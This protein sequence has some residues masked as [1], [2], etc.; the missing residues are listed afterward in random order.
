MEFKA[1]VPHTLYHYSYGC[2]HC[3]CCCCCWTHIHIFIFSFQPNLCISSSCQCTHFGSLDV[4]SMSTYTEIYIHRQCIYIIHKNKSQG[5][6]HYFIWL[7]HLIPRAPS[8]PLHYSTL[9]TSSCIYGHA[10]AEIVQDR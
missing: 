2:Y 9:L 10:Y 3:C 4:H 7:L 8:C 1:R 6:S 5:N